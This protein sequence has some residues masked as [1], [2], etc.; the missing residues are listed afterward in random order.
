MTRLYIVAD[1]SMLG[2]E[3]GTLGNVK[4]TAYVEAEMRRMGLQPAGEN[5]T[6]FQTV[7]VV[8]SR[9]DTT[10]T[11]SVAGAPLALG[12]DVLPITSAVSR[13]LPQGDSARALDGPRWCTAASSVGRRP[14]ST[15]R[16]R[17][18]GGGVH[19]APR[20]DGRREWRFYRVA[21]LTSYAGAAGI[22]A[23]TLDAVP[24][25]TL[26]R[27]RGTQEGIAVAA[28]AGLA[29]RVF[30]VTPTAAA[31]LLGADPRDGLAPAPRGAR[32]PA[33][34]PSSPRPRPTRRA[35]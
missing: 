11:I 27:L 2:R 28:D 12:L 9:L 4:S 31:R 15:P 19:R 8:I 29:P 20:L 23:A 35:T 7:P 32:S 17:G 3:S 24:E 14:C 25:A 18:Q 16:G 26:A 34:W 1:D 21:P 22:A 6:F 5:G 30:L 13:A 33:S 10:R